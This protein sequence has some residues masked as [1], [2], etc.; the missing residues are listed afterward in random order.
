[1]VAHDP[2]DRRCLLW[3]GLRF[4]ESVKEAN[5]DEEACKYQWRSGDGVDRRALSRFE[6]RDEA[7]SRYSIA[8]H[9][10]LNIRSLGLPLGR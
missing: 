9:W 10:A 5:E 4:R 6:F 1:M 8:R 7:R 2:I 3:K